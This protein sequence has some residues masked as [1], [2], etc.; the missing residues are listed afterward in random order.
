MYA[1]VKIAGKQWRLQERDRILIDKLPVKKNDNFTIEQVL[2]LKKENDIL[3]GNPFVEKAVVQ[4]KVL[5]QIRDKKIIVFKKKRRKGYKKKQ[6][7]RQYKTILLVEK[8]LLDGKSISKQKP[9][10]NDKIINN[11]Q[12]NASAAA[13]V[14]LTNTNTATTKQLQTKNTD[15]NISDK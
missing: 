11:A 5:E 10:A 13:V 3:I 15:K 9:V 12:N 8:I 14:D 6:G 1:V 4:T 7:H 2:L